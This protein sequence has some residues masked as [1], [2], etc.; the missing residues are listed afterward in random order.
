MSTHRGS[1]DHALTTYSLQQIAEGAPAPGPAPVIVAPPI[2]Q[3]SSEGPKIIYIP[4]NVYVPVIKPVFVPR[5]RKS[6][7][8]MMFDENHD[9]CL[10]SQG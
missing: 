5:E 3:G 7:Q 8:R 10:V 6:P 4:R 9:R 1:L 2:H